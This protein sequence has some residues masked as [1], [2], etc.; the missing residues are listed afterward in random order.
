MVLAGFRKPFR[1]MFI[2]LVHSESPILP[3]MFGG[4]VVYDELRSAWPET[5]VRQAIV[6]AKK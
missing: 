4:D 6:I 1:V 5:P 3:L 2:P